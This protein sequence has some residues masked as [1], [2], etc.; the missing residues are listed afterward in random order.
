MYA[1]MFVYMHA[2]NKIKLIQGNNLRG[3]SL[4]CIAGRV[5]GRVR[6]EENQEGR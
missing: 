6:R 1:Y 2:T 5:A 3:G 4:L